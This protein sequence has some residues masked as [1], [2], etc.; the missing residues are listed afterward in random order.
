MYCHAYFDYS[1]GIG[2]TSNEVAKQIVAEAKAHLV[3][4]RFFACLSLINPWRMRC[5]GYSSRVCV[6]YHASCYIPRL[7][8]NQGFIWRFQHMPFVENQFWQ[9]LLSTSAFFT[10]WRALDGQ[11][12]DGF[13]SKRLVCRSSERSYDST[14]SSLAIVNCQTMLLALNFLR[15]Y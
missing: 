3:R 6:R 13:F 8:W 2:H 1:L 7:C 4:Y 9:H 10:F 15:V 14:D 12:S 5:E 11:N